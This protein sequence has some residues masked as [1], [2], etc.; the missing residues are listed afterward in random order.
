[1]ATTLQNGLRNDINLIDDTVQEI[2]NN[3]NLTRKRR[4]T[5]IT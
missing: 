5:K 2:I 4:K 3:K 1:V